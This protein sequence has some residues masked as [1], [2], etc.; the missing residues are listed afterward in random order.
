MSATT[1]G[2]EYGATAIALH[3]IVAILIFGN[4]ALGLYTVEVLPL[5]PQKLRFF[6]WHKWIGV[7]VLILASLRLA[8]RLGIRLRPCPPP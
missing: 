6:S 4:L 1:G 7:T 3:W 8:W 5:S 2:R